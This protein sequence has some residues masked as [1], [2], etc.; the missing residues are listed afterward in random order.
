MKATF[1][2]VFA[3]ALVLALALSGCNLVGIDAK[4][5]ADED[6]AKIDKEYAAAVATYDGGEVTVGEAI[7]AF[8]ETY[9]ETAYMYSYFGIAMDHEQIHEMIESTLEQKVR[10]EIAAAHYDAEHSLSDEELA[11]VES[12][13]Q[14]NYEANLESAKES[15]E[16]NDD[17][18][19]AEYARVLLR[20][21]GMDYDAQYADGLL[22]AKNDAM[23]QLLRDEIAEL[24]DEELQAAYDDKVAEQKESFT[25][26]SSFESAMSG[27]SEIVCWMPD[28]YRT[29]KHILLMPSDE[30]KSA[31]TTAVSAQTSA[32][33]SLDDLKDELDA[34]NDDTAEE[35]ERTA[36]QIQADIDA[37]EA[38]LES[39]NADV[40][41]AAQ[42]CLDEVKDTADEIYGRLE[43]GE[44]FEDLIAEYGQ[45]PGMTSEP[46]KTRGY[47][48]SSESTSW[49]TNFRDA[50]MALAQ[51]GDYTAEPVV[52]GSGVHIIQYTGDV[53]GGEVPLDDVR[54]ALYDEALEARKTEHVTETIDS[55]VEEANPSY[56][57]EAFEAAVM[58]EE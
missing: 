20:S 9:T 52:S 1:A 25:D 56:D 11:E 14:S 44:S 23:E 38:T 30:T 13:A 54:D 22:N 37:A 4:M 51:V 46:T 12:T 5:Q 32:Q 39:C 31:Y 18:E 8:N 6:I 3:L 16:G 47:Y 19:R 36:E 41:S 53:L 26:G 34:A 24:T 40:E 50:A 42:A 17:A 45:D 48:V 15:A 57:A 43:A 35:G 7:N 21:N 2:K 27:D 55:W 28:G 58:A 29:V 10:S 33:T 49:E